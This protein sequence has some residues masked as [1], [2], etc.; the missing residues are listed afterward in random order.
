MQALISLLQQTGFDLSAT[1]VA[2]VLWLAWQIGDQT[3]DRVKPIEAET[4]GASDQRSP[5]PP[6][7]NLLSTETRAESTPEQPMESS[8]FP[9]ARSAESAQVYPS[10]SGAPEP[11]QL[12]IR[13]PD[14]PAL[15]EPLALARALRPLMR[16]VPSR[17][18]MVLD[19]EA[20]VTQ[21][22]DEKIWSLVQRPAPER[23]LDLALVIEETTALPI[24]QKTIHAFQTLVERHGAFRDVRSWRLRPDQTGTL[25]LFLGTETQG[26]RVRSPKELLDASG[27]RLILLVS[28]GVSPAWKSGQMLP[29]L[30]Q[31]AARDMLAMLQ[32]LP[33]RYWERTALGL[34]Y[35]VQV[36]A[37][38]PGTANAQLGL[39]GLPGWAEVELAQTLTLPIV[40]LEAQSLHRWAGVLAAIGGN[41]AVGTVLDP[42][43]FAAKVA[44]QPGESGSPEVSD[45]QRFRQ[46]WSTASPQ[47]RQLAGCL[48]AVPV[49]MPVV[50]LVQQAI[51]PES[52]PVEVAEVFFSGIL[53]RID[54]LGVPLRKGNSEDAD[55]VQ[56]EFVGDIRERL[57]GT[58]RISDTWEVL[59]LISAQIA[60][61]LG[62]ATRDFAA[63]LQVASQGSVGQRSELL[64]FARIAGRV[65]RRLG[66]EYASWAEQLGLDSL[67]GGRGAEDGG[68]RTEDGEQRIEDGTVAS[69]A[70]PAEQEFEFRTATVAFE[71]EEASS[72]VE[73]RPEEESDSETIEATW[74]KFEAEF[75]TLQAPDSSQGKLMYVFLRRTL[76]NFHL[77]DNHSEASI[78]N[79]AYLRAHQL[80]HAGGRIDT[81]VA[82]LRKTAY[83]IIR[84]LRIEQN[85]LISSDLNL[86][87]LVDARNWEN[88]DLA[89]LE[90]FAFETA[91]V[92]FQAAGQ[93]VIARRQGQAWGY[94][95]QLSDSIALE[96]VAIAG[97]KFLMGSLEDEP[98]CYSSEGP[99]REVTVPPFYLSKYPV[100]QAQWRFVSGLPRVRQTLDPAPSRFKGKERP[101][102]QI[103][104]HE[105]VEFC[106]RLSEATGETYRLPSEAE[107]EY[108]CRAG[109]T[110]PF[111]FGKTITPELANYDSNFTYGGGP[112]GTYRNQTT[113]VGSFPA[114]AWGLYD[115]HGNVCEWCADHWH[116]NYQNAPIHGSAWVDEDLNAD[117][118]RVLRGGS[119]F[120]LPGDCRSANRDYY[121]A[122][123]CDND[124][125]FRLCCSVPRT[126]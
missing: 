13:I 43:I 9:E 95:E 40:T 27:R 107:W 86:N 32:L 100:T 83:N 123:L 126:L 85:R 8:S 69:V 89:P 48:A 81:P 36:T 19:E 52:S 87:E 65:L 77:R 78:L 7:D 82:W 102:E 110:N 84:E 49:S 105:A 29:L 42:A 104:W 18:Q 63:V 33:E 116:N 26:G 47:A 92:V 22:A 109:T 35:P 34:G 21:I 4:I 54:P 98:E 66:G 38:Q 99:Q 118:A 68:R 61:K 1:E 12:P 90:R 67:S 15:R 60:E 5:P 122:W 51:V 76:Q 70:F 91:T 45:E 14:A 53:R 96:M 24:W 119:W 62:L 58:R 46:F 6:P 73:P 121:V 112:N 115:M 23:W 31:W 113:P 59:E 72:V 75:L 124:I 28:D 57:I 71:E 97:G 125:G 114:N 88:G 64:P 17:T 101:V 44:Q 30:E 2:D 11:S 10:R 108:A 94:I 25:Q 41:Q 16:P 120:D 117:A 106:A 79:E 37:W 103:S 74:R 56:Y 80:I 55:E 111:A 20:T 93:L 3:S 50:R 39:V